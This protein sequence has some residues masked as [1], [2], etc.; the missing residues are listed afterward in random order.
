MKRFVLFIIFALSLSAGH[1]QDVYNYVL[2]NATRVVNNPTSS[3]T[4]TRIA[5]FKRTALIYLRS[6]AIETKGEVTTEFLDNQAFYMS[7]FLTSFFKEVLRY[8]KKPEAAKRKAIVRLFMKA[9]EES[10][11]FNDTDEETTLSYV[12]SGE[13]ITPFSLDTDWQRAFAASQVMLK[14]M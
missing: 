7:E 8:D 3:F 1:A 9:S 11:L 4:Q 14:E 2:S 12:K 10:P 6:K 13:E 5:Q